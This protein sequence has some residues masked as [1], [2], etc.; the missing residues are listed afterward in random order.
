M[1]AIQKRGYLRVATSGDVVLWGATDPNT[2][3]PQGYDV[4]LAA[5]IAR[6]LG[7]DPAKTV[8]TVIPYSQR[9][10]VLKNDQVDLVA[11]QMTITCSRWSGAAKTATTT[12]NP[13]INLSIPYYTAGAR[14]LVRS[15]STVKTVA[16]L[17]GQPVCGT[18]KST[19]LETIAKVGVTKVEAPSAGQCLVKFEE[20]EVVAVVGDETTL[21]GF[22]KQNPRSKIVGTSLNPGQYGIGTRAFF[23][24]ETNFDD[25]SNFSETQADDFTRF[26]NA[27]LEQLRS[28][29]TLTKLYNTWMKPSVGGSAPSLSAPVYGRDI[30]GLKRAS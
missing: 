4:D 28:D 11:Q 15:D 5:E 22:K 20:G 13:G 26:V 12:A 16:D 14:F 18:A 24:G 8:Y 29:G 23:A 25:K 30:A 27:V 19:S 2:G 9:Q 7:V 3:N 6:R 17:K 1:A 21:A 10:S